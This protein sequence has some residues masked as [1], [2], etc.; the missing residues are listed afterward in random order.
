VPRDVSLICLLASTAMLTRPTLSATDSA[1]DS[2]RIYAH[3]A[4][5]LQ[6]L[7]NGGRPATQQEYYRCPL[8]LRASLGPAP[9]P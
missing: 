5:M 2:R 3:A 7:I 8:H 4:E 9:Q 6:T 1:A